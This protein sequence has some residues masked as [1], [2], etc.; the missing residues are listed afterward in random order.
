MSL[1]LLSHQRLRDTVSQPLPFSD[2]IS[3]RQDQVHQEQRRILRRHAPR[4]RSFKVFK[5]ALAPALR[6]TI[7]QP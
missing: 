6:D 5:A 3:A 2:G 7:P 1:R 4:L